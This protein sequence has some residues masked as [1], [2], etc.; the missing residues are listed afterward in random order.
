MSATGESRDRV[1]NSVAVAS[2]AYQQE[3]RTLRRI[4]DIAHDNKRGL[5]VEQLCEASG[6]DQTFV[7]QLLEEAGQS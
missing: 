3:L 5:T 2:L 4:L 7:K 1:W 6:L